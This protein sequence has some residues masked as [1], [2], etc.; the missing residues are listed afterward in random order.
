MTKSR[1]PA[2]ALAKL[3]SS[4]LTEAHAAALGISFLRAPAVK[5]LHPAFEATDALHISYADPWAQDPSSGF[6]DLPDRPPF[7]RLRYLWTT[8]GSAFGEKDTRRRYTN[9]PGFMVHAYFPTCEGVDWP[10]LLTDPAEPLFITE[11]ELKA[12]KATVEGFPTIGLGGVDSFSSR[13]RGV[14]LLPEL[15]K[16]VWAKR[17]VYVVY[18]SD[19]A[20][21]PEVRRAM[22]RL[23]KTLGQRGA[24]T[25]EVMLPAGENGD[26]PK[27]GLDDF[28]V[29][30][31]PDAFTV[32][33]GSTFER[34]PEPLAQNEPLFTLNDE[35]VY[36]LASGLVVHQRSGVLWRPETFR[37]AYAPLPKVRER[38][39]TK[40]GPGWK[41]TEATV[42][43]LQWPQRCAV[44]SLTYQPLRAG[45]QEP[46]LTPH[47]DPFRSTW[48]V[49][50]GWGVEP[51]AGAHPEGVQPF[52]DVVD[53]VFS[54]AEPGAKEWFLRWLACPLQNPGAK[55]FTAVLL[56]GRGQGT[57]K[58]LMGHT[59]KRIYGA[60]YT[61]IGNEEL[62]STFNGW[63]ARRQFVLGD[64]IA[65][66]DKRE[67]MDKL[68]RMIT[69]PVV[70]VNEKNLP[71]Y[72]LA[73]CANLLLTSNH[74]NALSLR[75][76][77]RR[78]FVHHVT[79]PSLDDEFY[80]PYY[81]WLDTGGAACLFDY[82]LRLPLG[83]FNEK[84]RAP[85]TSAK[86]A[87]IAHSY[88]DV[89]QWARDLAADADSVLAGHPLFKT[90]GD[91]W[92]P[93]QLLEAYDPE[94]RTR[95][96]SRGLGL[97]L[98]DLVPKAHG[99]DQ[100]RGPQGKQYYYIIRNQERWLA[101]T[102]DELKAHLADPRAPVGNV[103]TVSRARRVGGR[104]Y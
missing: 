43:W 55:L 20:T 98:L 48:N 41:E 40:Q 13:G 103:T 7:Y 75:D 52:L 35:V 80:M 61:E 28:L 85:M 92:T 78:V 82:L 12:A 101:A 34:G 17:R 8:P 29:A 81:L 84:S 74:P 3:A 1:W 31:G 89:E 42:A 86:A 32:L 83:D 99:G 45:S 59:M 27:V 22:N 53:H 5:N 4:G 47:E 68:K 69:Q 87:M 79:A 104:K 16:V 63:A 9:E 11:G 15:E 62:A 72:E 66:S 21:K 97:A 54:G 25:F 14:T 100:I 94:G 67:F 33:L 38:T 60:N 95:V 51:D 77:D 36:V 26:A 49:W 10:A 37:L 39:E 96:K 65:G 18:D 46:R 24:L 70:R 93:A 6:H 57:G 58:S 102:L 71:A 76:E 88:S 30:N 19:A 90:L 50:P 64:E 23:A 44:G 2:H 73:D 56:H 91:L